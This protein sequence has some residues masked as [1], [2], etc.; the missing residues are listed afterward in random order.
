MLSTNWKQ[1]INELI[2]NVNG[3]ATKIVKIINVFSKE[4]ID[5]FDTDKTMLSWFMIGKKSN[6]LKLNAN[7][8]EKK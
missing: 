2:N 8:I 1:K 3:L 5:N 6:S 7:F 4:F